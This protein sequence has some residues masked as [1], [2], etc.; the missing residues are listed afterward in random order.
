MRKTRVENLRAATRKAAARKA[1]ATRA[2]RRQPRKGALIKGM[3][4]QLPSE[5]LTSVAFR[6]RLKELMKG[7]A[8]IYALYKRGRLYYVGLA[9]NLFGRINWHLKDRHAG[10]WDS[11]VIFRIRRV[12]YLKDIETLVLNII[13]PRGNRRAG[14]VP[15]DADINRMLQSIVHQHM[16]EVKGIQ[17]ALKRR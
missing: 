4:R 1:A 7:Y 14:K 3:T 12:G 8:G 11:F 5:I 15:R 16:R 2:S 17:K 10:K 13:S 6:K 9:T